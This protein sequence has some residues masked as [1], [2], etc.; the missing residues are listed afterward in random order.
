MGGLVWLASYP[1]S[2]NTWLRAFLHNLLSNKDEPVDINDLMELSV[3]DTL[4]EWYAEVAGGDI[5]RLSEKE[6][7][8]LRPRVHR[9]L[10]ELSKN[11][12][13]VKTHNIL[14]TDRGVSLITMEVTVGAIYVVRNPLDMVLS[15]GPH[16][17]LTIDQAIE[18]MALEKARTPP[19]RANVEQLLSS[20]SSHVKSWTRQPHERIHVVRYEDMHLSPIETFAQIAK[21]L[22]IDFRIDRIEK[23]VRF[24]AFDVLRAQED[25]HGFRERSIHADK[26]FRAG[27]AGAWRDRLSPKQ[28]DAIISR[29]REQMA[30]F[31]YLPK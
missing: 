11:S 20:W 18:M 9:R 2:G 29:H 5:S 22:E 12:V 8:Q 7:A 10:T 30:R 21:F 17:G 14:G 19:D 16:F 26:F 23:A 27:K 3:G 6:I 28:V 4:K 31:D 13:F 24:S 1:K 25:Q 15:L